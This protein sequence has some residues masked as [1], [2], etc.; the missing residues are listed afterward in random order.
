MQYCEKV[1]VP[2]KFLKNILLGKWEIGAVSYSK[3]KF[4]YSR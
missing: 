2:P 3:H 1:L 4:R